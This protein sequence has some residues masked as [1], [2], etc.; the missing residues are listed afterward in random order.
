MRT[1]EE[2]GK[3]GKKIYR[4]RTGHVQG[5]RIRPESSPR[6]YSF[7]QCS[8]QLERDILRL[9]TTTE[10]QWVPHLLRAFQ[11]P[12]HLELVVDYAEGGTLWGRVEVQHAGR[13]DFRTRY[14]MVGTTNRQRDSLVS[15]T[16]FCAQVGLRFACMNSF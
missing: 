3:K 4:Y 6:E 7:Q 11:T 10:S 14:Q 9:A 5:I 16:R 12:M 8:P 1:T 2:K 13:Q 15:L